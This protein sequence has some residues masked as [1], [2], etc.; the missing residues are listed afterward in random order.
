MVFPISLHI[1]QKKL[2]RS[3]GRFGQFADLIN[4]ACTSIAWLKE[5]GMKHVLESLEL[6]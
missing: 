6:L 3:R 4:G 5:F 1:I 2:H